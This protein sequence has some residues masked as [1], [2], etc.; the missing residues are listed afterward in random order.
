LSCLRENKQLL[1][2]LNLLHFVSFVG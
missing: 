1:G 2:Q